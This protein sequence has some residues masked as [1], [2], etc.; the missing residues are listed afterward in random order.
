[1][2]HLKFA[3]AKLLFFSIGLALTGSCSLSNSNW[4]NVKKTTEVYPTDTI[5]L[6]R[7]AT[8]G[9]PELRWINESYRNYRYKKYYQHLVQASF[10]LSNSKVASWLFRDS[11]SIA[12]SLQDHFKQKGITHFVGQ[13]M[14]G[15][16]L[17]IFL[18]HE[19]GPEPV[20]IL[21]NFSIPNIGLI[22][23]DPEWQV[24]SSLLVKK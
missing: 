17:K 12:R 3:T 18:Y 7:I 15:N 9:S 1:M 14:A 5:R 16:E 19:D 4:D 8:N 6:Y 10:E 13:T 2:T 24:Y 21:F 20:S 22:K 23:T 11:L